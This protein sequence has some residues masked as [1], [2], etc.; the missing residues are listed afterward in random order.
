MRADLV[1]RMVMRPA[2]ASRAGGRGGRMLE[3]GR[4]ACRI[5]V[6]PARRWT[7]GRGQERHS[8]RVSLAFPPIVTTS[9]WPGAGTGC[10]NEGTMSHDKI[11][12]AARRR[13][14]QTGEP[15]T[16]ARRAVIGEHRAVAGSEDPPGEPR[17][18]AISYR[19]RGLDRLTAWSDTLLFRSGP[20]VAGVEIGADEIRVRMGSFKLDIPPQFGARRLAFVHRRA[21]HDRRAR[22]AGAVAGQRRPRRPGGAGH[23]AAVLPRPGHR[24]AI[25]PGEGGPADREPGRPRRVHRGHA[26]TGRL[27]TYCPKL[28]RSAGAGVPAAAARSRA[29]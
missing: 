1:P 12:A 7:D 11:S 9:R 22:R 20:G 17:W 18:F 26:L 5:R 16:A 23:R 2:A 10:R 25:P 19:E 14:A 4:H 24:H 8:P 28:C 6:M 3:R 21:R 15:Y 29:P 13:M 27:F